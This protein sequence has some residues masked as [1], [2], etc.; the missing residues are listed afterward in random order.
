MD[1][2]TLKSELLK[3]ARNA[4]ETASTLR[5]NERIEVYLHNG[6]PKT[7]D[8]LDESDEI[9]YGDNRLLCYQVS[10]NFV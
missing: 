2:E 8:I 7:S 4:F 9:V 5:D 6:I 3:Q 10:Y 1:K